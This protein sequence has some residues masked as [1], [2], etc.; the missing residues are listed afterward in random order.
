[1]DYVFA[2]ILYCFQLQSTLIPTMWCPKRMSSCILDTLYTFTVLEILQKATSSFFIFIC[3]ICRHYLYVF[4]SQY[5]HSST[6]NWWSEL[7]N[8]GCICKTVEDLVKPLQT[9]YLLISEA[10]KQINL[11]IDFVH[12]QIYKWDKWWLTGV[13]V[14][15][16]KRLE[17][18]GFSQASLHY[19]SF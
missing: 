3:N 1:M 9:I 12:V 15:E 11:K 8:I 17:R 16:K 4:E 14:L 10:A 6:T 13:V 7:L 5:F 19:S 18:K 2:L